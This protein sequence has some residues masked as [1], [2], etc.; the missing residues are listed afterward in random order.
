MSVH[1]INR[2]LRALATLNDLKVNASLT[3]TRALLIIMAR[4]GINQHQ[5]QDLLKTNSA[6]A[7]RSIALWKYWEREPD[8][9]KNYK[10]IR[11]ANLVSAEVDP[12]DTRSR[13]LILSPLGKIIRQQIIED[14]GN[15]GTTRK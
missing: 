5:V 7:H 11:G 13:L 9:S 12:D 3:Q 4:E 1:S 8:P 15:G 2:I 14:I 6:T 10:G